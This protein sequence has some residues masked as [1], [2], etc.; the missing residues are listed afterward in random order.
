MWIQDIINVE[1]LL[2]YAQTWWPTKLPALLKKKK[3]LGVL[4]QNVTQS[5][6]CTK[7]TVVRFQTRMLRNEFIEMV[8]TGILKEQTFKTKYKIFVH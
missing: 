3:S 1:L 8:Y 6:R 5:L 4:T 7:M 2:N